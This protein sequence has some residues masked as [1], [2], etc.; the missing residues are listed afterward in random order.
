MLDV[1]INKKA[2]GVIRWG[3]NVLVCVCLFVS[4]RV[5][6][7]KRE[8]KHVVEGD[9]EREGESK[10][11]I[12]TVDLYTSS[13]AKIFPNWS[14]QYNSFIDVVIENCKLDR[15]NAINLQHISSSFN[16]GAS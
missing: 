5:C 11:L 10:T 9:K 16:T 12:P 1:L 13:H 2:D 14:G 8:K 4:V 7:R 15:S 3:V 6:E